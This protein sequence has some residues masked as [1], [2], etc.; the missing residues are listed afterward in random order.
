MSQDVFKHITRKQVQRSRSRSFSGRSERSP[1]SSFPKKENGLTSTTRS[2]L[3]AF[4]S[5]SR[6]SFSYS[7]LIIRDGVNGYL[8]L[9]ANASNTWESL[10]E[11][12]LRRTGE[13]L[14]GNYTIS[15]AALGDEKDRSPF[16]TRPKKRRSLGDIYY[17]PVPGKQHT[18]SAIDG[19]LQ[20][21]ATTND[22]T[23]S[24]W[25]ANDYFCLLFG[26]TGSKLNRHNVFDIFPKAF[27]SYLS[28]LMISFP[29][30]N[31][32]ERVLFCGD[33][34]PVK[35][36]DGIRVMDFWVK[37]K[38][39]KLIWI[40]EFVEE[41]Y[42]DFQLS[43]DDRV[44]DLKTGEPLV[45]DFLPSQLPRSWD[46][47]LYLATRMSTGLICPSMVYPLSGNTYQ[48]TIFHYAAGLLFLNK[49]RKIVSLNEAVFESMLGFSD[50][51]TRDI[52]LIF[53][54]FNKILDLLL[55]SHFLDPGR[56]VSE[57]HVRH[58]YYRIKSY[59]ADIGDRPELVHADGHRIKVDCQI[60]SVSPISDYPSEPAFGVWL[61]FDSVDNRASNYI[62]SKR[63]AKLLEEAVKSDQTNDLEGPEQAGDKSSPEME[64]TWENVPQK[65]SMYNTVKE[66]GI[67]A[68]GQV[69]LV[70]YKCQKVHEV[71][72]KSINKSRILLDS[73]MRDKEL[74][75]VPMEISI[76]NFL[77]YNPHPNIVKMISF[78]EDN[79]NYYLLT[80]PQIP[81]IDLFDYIEVRSSIS[82]VEC[83]AIFYQIVL[84]ISHLHAFDIVH[85]DI[86][87]ENI[88]LEQSG[89]A[90][91]IDFGSSSLTRKGPF[92]TFRGTVGFA[93]PELLKG[94]R[95]LGKE[96][97]VWALGIL[98][99]TIVYRENPYYNIEEIL[100]GDLRIPF[101]VSK[102][103]VDLIYRMLDRNVQARITIE[104]A[105]Q[106]CWFDDVRTL[107]LSHIP[108]PLTL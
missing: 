70:S 85:R 88:I 68:Y 101:E 31:E 95:Y 81:G 54:D 19:P 99:Y 46:E 103:S 62:S 24:I 107:D 4:S 59:N 65:I 73:W 84:A 86:K 23:F 3:L 90:R 53:P 9:D 97:D 50:L 12:E 1:S 35:T 13:E 21:I 82:E 37:E 10:P 57:L 69:K 34:F 93:A 38:A 72:L 61:I 92:D 29:I 74:G 87:D 78:F 105:I 43:S 48:Y 20:A 42:I 104:E 47:R 77:K 76:L 18:S 2:R 66:L 58:A 6:Y 71:I 44:I 8:P 96:Q 36:V 83:K 75:T 40:L 100:D 56:V 108:V 25:S 80:E 28:S 32:H 7:P 26:L 45:L 106:H 30:D 51:L 67:G 14:F 11:T 102:E 39:G 55:D 79:D 22:T 63:S 16:T 64:G 27:A 41:S 5:S 89:V 98:L 60:I 15:T 49:G 94:E 52:S 33:V 17:V 91:L